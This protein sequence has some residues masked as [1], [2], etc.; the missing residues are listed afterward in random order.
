MRDCKGIN[1]RLSEDPMEM[2]NLV[3]GITLL[4]FTSYLHYVSSL[5]LG[6]PIYKVGLFRVVNELIPIRCLEQYLVNL[7]MN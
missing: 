3:S 4:R 6:T 5:C 2:K 1:Y 7:N